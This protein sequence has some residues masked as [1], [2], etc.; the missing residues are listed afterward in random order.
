MCETTLAMLKVNK[1]GTRSN[2]R[3]YLGETKFFISTSLKSLS[4]FCHCYSILFLSLYLNFHLDSLHR[5]PNSPHFCISI[6]IP[7][8]LTMIPRTRIPIP[9]L[10]FPP[11]FS[12]FSSCRSTIPQF[13]F[14]RQPAQFDSLLRIYFWKIVALVQKRTL[15]FYN[16]KTIRLFSYRQH[17]YSISHDYQNRSFEIYSL[18]ILS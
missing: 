13:G 6:Q 2:A 17:V 11:L 12:A 18:N 15:L 1:K 8:I 7:C 3:N 14:C 16:F 9:F 5:H 10:A 4:Y